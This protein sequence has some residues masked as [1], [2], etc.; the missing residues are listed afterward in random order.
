MWEGTAGQRHITGKGPEG[1]KGSHV[2]KITNAQVFGAGSLQSKGTLRQ[3]AGEVAGYVRLTSRKPQH[4][5]EH[6]A[7]PP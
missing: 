6:V 1:R 2:Q 3:K 7:G 5:A 4:C